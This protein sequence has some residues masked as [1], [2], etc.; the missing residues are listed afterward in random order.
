MPVT[1]GQY[2][3]W[4]RGNPSTRLSWT[5]GKLR[6][7]EPQPNEFS[8]NQH[9]QDK[10]LSTTGSGRNA[11]GNSVAVVGGSAAGLYTA[12]LLARAGKAVRVFERAERLEPVARTLIVT[13]RMRDLLG[14]VAEPSIVN[15][16][17]DLSFTRTAVPP[18]FRW[19]A[20]T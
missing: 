20:R 12:S 18:P 10:L 9:R 5:S 7:L 8:L 4:D 2:Q 6:R 11:F 3:F 15:E 19:S 13:H 1:G 16:S 14:R 17:A